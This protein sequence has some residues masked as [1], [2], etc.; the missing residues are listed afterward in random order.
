MWQH[1]I[2]R[3]HKSN[4]SIEESELPPFLADMIADSSPGDDKTVVNSVLA[5]SKDI[6]FNPFLN[7]DGSLACFPQAGFSLSLGSGD[8]KESALKSPTLVS[9]D[10]TKTLLDALNR[11]SVASSD[12][13]SGSGFS[14]LKKSH[15]IVITPTGIPI[16]LLP[17]PTSLLTSGST[18]GL[19]SLSA[20]FSQQQQQLQNANS[21]MVKKE[22]KENEKN[23][24]TIKSAEFSSSENGVGHSATARRSSL[25]RSHSSSSAHY[26]ENGDS[27]QSDISTAVASSSQP[28]NSVTALPPSK[29][30]T[31]TCSIKDRSGRRKRIPMSRSLN[32]QKPTISIQKYHHHLADK[33]GTCSQETPTTNHLHKIIDRLA[34]IASEKNSCINSQQD[35]TQI[36][37]NSNNVDVSNSR[38]SSGEDDRISSSRFTTN[39]VQSEEAIYALAGFESA[40]LWNELKRRKSV[41]ECDCGQLF[42]EKILYVLHCG[43]HSRQRDDEGL[44]CCCDCD[45]A[46]HSWTDFLAHILSHQ[47]Q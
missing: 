4:R 46:A 33:N 1:F 20:C 10:V 37:H 15:C 11:E 12:E 29:N 30:D 44:K 13:N 25:P 2:E 31:T 22:P 19:Q 16:G 28:T 27:N 36:D 41:F 17:V 40:T 9:S 42:T 45:F 39:C 32:G 21:I 6:L 43:S 35:N 34:D 23:L 47:E 3:H 14:D 8:A 7:S 38:R 24:E 26:H 18:A 5:A